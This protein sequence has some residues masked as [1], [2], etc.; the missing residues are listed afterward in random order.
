[1]SVKNPAPIFMFDMDG[2]LLDLAYDDFIWNKHL[3][4]RYAAHHQCSLEESQSILFRYYQQYKHT[5][6]W[7]SSRA[8][9]EK[10]GLDMFAMQLE[11]QERI[12]LRPGCIALLEQLKQQGHRCWIVTNADEA[13]LEMKM[14]RTGIA[15]YF[16]HLVSSE[17]LG[18]PKEQQGFWQTLQAQYPFDPKNVILI[19]DTAKVLDSAAQFG[20]QHL[21]TIDQP[22]SAEAPR[23]DLHYPAINA[24]DDL[25][26]LMNLAA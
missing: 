22:S 23:T 19:D 16:E 20:I 9:T 15:H 11:H 5:L 8:W 26:K 13:G 24:L 12:Q 14:Q 1:M 17:T 7:Y 3:P 2:T 6:S 25:L 10:V 21:V 4:I 18:Y